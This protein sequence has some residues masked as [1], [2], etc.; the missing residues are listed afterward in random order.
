MNKVFYFATDRSRLDLQKDSVKRELGVGIYLVNDE[1][2]ALEGNSGANVRLFGLPRLSD[3]TVMI[4]RFHM[5]S[6]AYINYIIDTI[7]GCSNPYDVVIAN[8]LSKSSLDLITDF[9]VK[10][11]HRYMQDKILKE[12]YRNEKDYKK[13]KIMQNSEY[14]EL[15]SKLIFEDT[16]ELVILSKRGIDWI[17][18][19][20]ALSKKSNTAVDLLNVNLDNS[21]F[22][23][24]K[25]EIKRK[26]SEYLGVSNIIYTT[27][28]MQ[29]QITGGI[30]LIFIRGKV[31]FINNGKQVVKVSYPEY[32]EEVLI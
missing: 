30:E 9:A 13:H 20:S 28:D 1:T 15:L 12:K 21:S 19:D 8:R 24:L 11:Y 5:A 26:G 23:L 7:W 25:D 4:N 31:V 32:K 16:L 27:D 3:T 14:T 22:N 17:E 10:N 29:Y 2:V 6:V 18:G